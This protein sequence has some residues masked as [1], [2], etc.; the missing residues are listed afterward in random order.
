MGG[1]L[2]LSLPYPC[3]KTTIKIYN[4]ILWVGKSIQIA[5]IVDCFEGGEA[6]QGA[7]VH[8]PSQI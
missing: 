8:S 2:F 1:S 7:T 5:I 3:R 6:D 4:L